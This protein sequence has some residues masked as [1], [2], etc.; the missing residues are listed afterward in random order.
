MLHTINRIISGLL[1]TVAISRHLALNNRGKICK[2]S[3]K[4]LLIVGRRKW[5]TL[6][7]GMF[8]WSSDYDLNHSLIEQGTVG[9]WSVFRAC[10]SGRT[11]F[12]WCPH[13]L[14]SVAY[15]LELAFC[16]LLFP[17]CFRS[18]VV[19]SLW[20]WLYETTSG[21]FKLGALHRSRKTVYLLPWQQ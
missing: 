13:I 21:A 19:P 15:G 18:H 7:R 3:P 17:S 14:A 5:S 1:N 9:S 8:Y 16:H 11:G 20:P 10:F 4:E 12:W 6:H 2:A